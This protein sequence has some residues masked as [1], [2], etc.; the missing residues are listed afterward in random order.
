M[1]KF[2]EIENETNDYSQYDIARA[3]L[4]Q[5]TR[6]CGGV[7]P[8]AINNHLY[9]F[10]DD[11]GIWHPDDDSLSAFS[12]INDVMESEYEGSPLCR[13]LSDYKAIAEIMLG[14]AGQGRRVDEFKR[15]PLNNICVDWVVYRPCRTGAKPHGEVKPQ[16]YCT[17]NFTLDEVG[18]PA[19]T[20]ALAAMASNTK[21]LGVLELFMCEA[22]GL[23]AMK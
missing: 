15:S 14:I 4:D 2:T 18:S 17:Y 11:E 21:T 7:P 22:L 8:I 1:N 19:Y 10:Y 13:T 12:L 20:A 9:S 6:F 3:L 5:T 16:H 23:E